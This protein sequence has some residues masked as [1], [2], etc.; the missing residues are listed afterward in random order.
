MIVTRMLGRDPPVAEAEDAE[1]VTQPAQ[2]ALPF[3]SR[4]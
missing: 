1:T 2:L 4:I 3:Y